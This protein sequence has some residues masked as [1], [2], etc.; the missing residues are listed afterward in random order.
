MWG[1]ILAS[2]WG[3]KNLPKPVQI[4]HPERPAAASGGDKKVT[5][6]PAE[7]R[8]FFHEHLRKG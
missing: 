5:N 3:A 4:Q 1:R 8:R 2:A 6:D 7:I